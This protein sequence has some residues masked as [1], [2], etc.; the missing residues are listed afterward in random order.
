MAN[1]N[2]WH[3]G[4]EIDTAVDKTF[5][6]E[7]IV[8]DRKTNLLSNDNSFGEYQQSFEVQ[9]GSLNSV[10]FY[11]EKEIKPTS[12]NDL[13]YEGK[14]YANIFIENNP[15]Q[16]LSFDNNIISSN[17]DNY[18]VGTPTSTPPTVSHSVYCTPNGSLH[19]VSTGSGGNLINTKM[20]VLTQADKSY[21]LA[22]MIRVDSYSSGSVGVRIDGVWYGGSVSTTGGQ[23][24]RKSA[25][26]TKGTLP[27]PYIYAGISTNGIAEC[28]IDEIV[29]IPLSEIFDIVPSQ[30]L[31]DS[32]YDNYIKLKSNDTANTQT[33]SLS[34]YYNKTSIA[35]VKNTFKFSDEEC[36]SAFVGAMNLKAKELKM[37]SANF[38]TPSGIADFYQDTPIYNICSPN[39]LL[40]LT[41]CACGY[42]DLMQIWGNS[43]IE[44]HIYGA[45]PRTIDRSNIVNFNN[46]NELNNGLKFTFVGAKGGSWNWNSEHWYSLCSVAI[47]P[48]QRA[49]AMVITMNV[50]S[51][52]L[53]PP[54]R[55]LV[56]IAYKAM[57]GEDISGMS[58]T[59][60][61]SAIACEI[62]VC[63]FGVQGYEIT[64]LY[65][66][67]NINDNTWNPASTSKILASIVAIDNCPD[68]Y[69][70]YT[71]MNPFDDVGWSGNVLRVGD[72]LSVK[73]TIATGMLLSSNNA[74]HTL[75]RYVGN[76]ILLNREKFVK[77]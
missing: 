20:G 67:G 51:A 64:P 13:A 69:N 11:P 72:I 28:Y 41:V 27:Q 68:I 18:W 52:S 48:N 63:G 16:Y 39:D 73:D 61:H 55:E 35:D 24:V 58:V 38:V 71:L 25:I 59:G 54:T 49:I 45:Q 76:R 65:S 56:Y 4:V 21:Y 66:Q 2:S 23:F 46:L 43:T 8:E 10:A 26:V 19:C 60:V 70:E 34:E 77:R 31:M 9:N 12:L 47:T 50:A 29:F 42:K 33:I 6:L 17:I 37:S 1:Y 22:Y 57:V 14:T 3:T 40:K 15:V 75:A 7:Q 74:I 62:P 36:V 44:T 5:E 30:N 32:L 53:V